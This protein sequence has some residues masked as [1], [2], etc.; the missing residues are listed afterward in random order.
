MT[1]TTLRPGTS[2]DSYA[3]FLVFEETLA[4]LMRRY[5]PHART[6]FADPE[7]LARMWDERR[8]LYEH[9]ARTAE[10]FWVAEQQGQVVGFARSILRDGLRQLTEF[11]VLPNVQSTGAGAALLAQ[12]F[13]TGGATR[14]SIIATPLPSAQVRYLR[15]GVY[16]RFP[17]SYWWRQPKP[18]ALATDLIVEPIA[19]SP[20]ALGILGGIDAAILGHRRDEDHAWLLGDR[21]GW[22]YL[23]QGAPV[24]YGYTGLRNG[25]FALLDPADFP[26]VLAHAENQ[27][28][29]AGRNHFGLEVPMINVTAIRHLL[30]RSFRME[31]FL[32]LAMSDAPFGRFEHYLVT[33]PPFFL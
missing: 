15:A 26:A 22:L 30:D 28:A 23:R 14:R 29:A 7:A 13:P 5:D 2:E 3:V 25:P 4:D 11:F 6:S 32:A 10:H 24:G 8:P 12:A 18:L 21:Q 17:I 16:P 31:S 19:A 9:L 1:E 27:A 20:E 33:T